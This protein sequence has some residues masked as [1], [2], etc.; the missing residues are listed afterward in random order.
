MYRSAE[1]S[2]QT[3]VAMTQKR[4]LKREKSRRHQGTEIII[5]ARSF[6]IS[7]EGRGER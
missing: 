7:L 2:K 4:A 5:N 3:T 1:E 6:L